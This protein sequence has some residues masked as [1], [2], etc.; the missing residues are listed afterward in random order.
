MYRIA[1][2][3]VLVLALGF[4][5]CVSDT[6]P[7]TTANGQVSEYVNATVEEEIIDRESERVREMLSE[8]DHAEY[9]VGGA[10]SLETTIV[11]TTDDGAYVRVSIPYW[12]TDQRTPSGSGG[13][14]TVTTVQVTGDATQTA[15]YFVNATAIERVSG[16]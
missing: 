5:G 12:F 3:C 9:G 11:N 4:A 6:S 8:R 15:V 16:G 7:T 2:A 13:N 10:G 14:R 1:I